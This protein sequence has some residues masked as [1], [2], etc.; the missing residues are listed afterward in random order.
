M[1]TKLRTKIRSLVEDFSTTDF[2]TFTYTTSNIFT[3]AEPNISSIDDVFIEGN[4]LQSGQSYVYAS[5]TNKITITADFT[6]G[7]SVEVDYTFTKYSDSELNKYIRAAL[8]WLSVYEYDSS[9]YELETLGIYPTPSNRTIDL[10]AIVASILINPDCTSYKLPNVSVAY[11]EQLPK[12]ER[13]QDLVSQFKF[14]IGAVGTVNWYESYY[15]NATDQTENLV[16]VG[17][18]TV[19]HYEDLE[20]NRKT[21]TSYLIEVQNHLGYLIDLTGGTMYF[22]AKTNMEDIDANAVIS[23]DITPAEPTLGRAF[24]ELDADDTDLVGSFYYDIKYVDADDN[25]YILFRGRMTFIE[26]VTERA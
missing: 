5:T 16:K 25:S 3:L 9:D 24:I 20:V 2:Q 13:I 7:N 6:S 10:I 21:Q 4:A 12:E 17:T 22:T 8:V 11:P 26:A 18:I 19:T 14:G 1:L 15:E 23:K